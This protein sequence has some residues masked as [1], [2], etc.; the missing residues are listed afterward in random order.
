MSV[1]VS[2]TPKSGKDAFST[3]IFAEINYRSAVLWMRGTC[4][5][6]LAKIETSPKKYRALVFSDVTTAEC[7][8]QK[9]LDS[10]RARK[11]NLREFVIKYQTV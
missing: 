10:M 3:L 8:V 5:V 11:P 6:E 9:L 4:L 1:Q 7:A 2:L